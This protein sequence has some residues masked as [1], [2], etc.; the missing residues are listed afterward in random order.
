MPNSPPELLALTATF[1][2]LTRLAAESDVCVAWLPGHEPSMGTAAEMLS[3]HRAGRSVVAVTAMRQNLAV[4]ACA[5]VI[6]PG[7]DAFDAW[8]AQSEGVG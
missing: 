7:L 4:L 1:H 3:A 5:T 6:V 2:R 8:L